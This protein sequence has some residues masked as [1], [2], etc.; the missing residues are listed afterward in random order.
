MRDDFLRMVQQSV[1]IT[2]VGP[3]ALRRQG[4]GVLAASHDFLASIS[5]AQLPKASSGRFAAW[6]DRQTEKLLDA[7][8][9]DGRPWGSARKAM[10]LFLRDALYNR[11]MAD[12]FQLDSVE[13][14]L[15][16]PLDS[17]VARGLKSQGLRGELP[18]WPGL[19]HL[20]PAISERFQD[21]AL[22]Y[23]REMGLARVHLD[24]YL[25]P[26]NR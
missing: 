4:R 10:N 3:S 2:A 6:L 25:W 15:E 7:F 23:A 11:Y 19:K 24:I 1:A 16:M 13:P 17:A 12:R 14:W 26:A 8:P 9:V 22:R 18:Q 5:L 20:T 21:F